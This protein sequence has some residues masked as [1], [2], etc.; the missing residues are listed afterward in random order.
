LNT[1]RGITLGA[2][3]AVAASAGAIV[4]EQREFAEPGQLERYKTLI[5]ELR[6]LVCQN[7]NIADSNAD[8]AADL[9]REVHRMILAGKSNEAIVEFMVTRYG[10]FVLYRP[11]LKAKTV[12]LW[13]GPF[14]LGIG[15][16]VLLLLQLRRRHADRA[17]AT[18][19]SDEER[20]RLQSLLDSD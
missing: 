17:T 20:A 18:P 7:Q 10:D 6:C 12:L 14:V 3:L 9:R 15:G 1:L 8:L 11:P 4:F 2:M 16:I 19:L 13:S 5:A